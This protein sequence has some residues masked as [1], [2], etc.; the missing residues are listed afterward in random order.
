VSQS[1]TWEHLLALAR[2]AAGRAY[3]PYSDFPVGAAL[4]A[5]DG[6]VFLGANIENASSSLTCCAE[7]VAIFHAVMEGAT[8]IAAVAVWAPKSRPCPPCGACRQVINEFGPDAVVISG[9]VEKTTAIISDLG[10]MVT[11]I[12]TAFGQRRSNPNAFDSLARRLL[13]MDAKLKQYT[14]GAL[15][16]RSVL[17]AV[18]MSEFNRI[19]TG[20]DTLPTRAEI[21]EPERW[22][23][24]VVRH[25]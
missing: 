21:D 10:S 19:W 24:R 22:V 12:R 18:G 5:T 13:G 20:P 7:R 14:H 2:D 11:S 9:L 6:R 4:L 17:D 25:G 23:N 3:A 15:F 16:V 1:D 8:E